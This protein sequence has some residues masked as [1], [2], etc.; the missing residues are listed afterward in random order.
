MWCHM[1]STTASN[2]SQWEGNS[3]QISL[4]YTFESVV[5]VSVPLSELKSSQEIDPEASNSLRLMWV[6][7]SPYWECINQES[8]IAWALQWRVHNRKPR[9]WNSGCLSQYHRQWCL[10][11]SSINIFTFQDPI[12]WGPSSLASDQGVGQDHVHFV[13]HNAKLFYCFPSRRRLLCTF[14]ASWAASSTKRL[15]TNYL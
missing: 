15:P 4:H 7:V 8:K 6:T 10:L 13:G 3:T 5:W 1:Q 11:I 9:N 14:N 2:S 12:M